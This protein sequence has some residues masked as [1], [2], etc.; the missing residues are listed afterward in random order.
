MSYATAADLLDNGP[1]RLAQ[2]AWPRG[3]GQAD[4]A[5]LV[6]LIAGDDVSIWSTDQQA[7]GQ[8]A[9]AVINAK[10]AEAHQIVE[11]AV[12]QQYSLPLPKPW[13]ILTVIEADIAWYRL[14]PNL[15]ETD[16]AGVRNRDA[17]AMLTRIA[18]G[19]LTPGWSLE[20]ASSVKIS[21]QQRVF[22]RD[23]LKG[24]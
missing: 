24:Y 10:L 21:S 7:V 18:A 13:P 14:H 16:T 11:A 9:L 4:A 12:G 2:L 23:R 19:K 22:S 6:A 20:A 3:Q 8:Q 1:E 17:Q 5:L 15:N